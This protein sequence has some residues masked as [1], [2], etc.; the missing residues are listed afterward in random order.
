M[1]VSH[2]TFN[3][4]VSNATNSM[5]LLVYHMNIDQSHQSVANILGEKLLSNTHKGVVCFHGQLMR[6]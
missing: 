4:A 2:K 6:L 3:L 1:I 5:L